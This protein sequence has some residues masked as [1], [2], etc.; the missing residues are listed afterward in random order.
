MTTKAATS[1]RTPKEPVLF[2]GMRS[3][4]TD[5][6]WAPSQ[7]LNS[8]LALPVR[9][10]SRQFFLRSRGSAVNSLRGFRCFL[11]VHKY[12][13]IQIHLLGDDR[14]RRNLAKTVSYLLLAT[15]FWLHGGPRAY[16]E[17]AGV[18]GAG[19][20][21]AR[22]SSAAGASL[23]PGEDFQF[24]SLLSET[25][26]L[27]ERDEAE[28]R[29][30]PEPEKG[31]R[32]IRK[33]FELKERLG[34]ENEKIRVYFDKL[35]DFIKRK[36]LSGEI[37]SRH[38]EFVRHYQTKYQT[39]EQKLGEIESTHKDA[40][41]FWGR[42][43]GK[44]KRVNWDGVLGKALVFLKENSPSA[45]ERRFDPKNLPNRTLRPEKPVLPK[46]TIDEWRQALPEYSG[47]AAAP[48]AGSKIEP[49][50]KLFATA[51]P[52]SADLAETVEVKFT[53]D[54]KDLADSLGRNPVKI[55][56]WVRN[57]IEFVP[58]WGSIQ[59]AQLCLENRAG[60][61]FDT[62][63]LLI[64]LLRYSGIHA[65]YQMGTIE[66]PIEK[67][68]NWA[69][70]FTSAEAA[71][72]LFAS[73]GVPSVVRRFDQ[74]G[75]VAGVK[76]EHIWVKGFV[77]YVPSAGVIN[78]QGDTWIDLDASF[79]QHT[80]PSPVDLSQFIAVR[81]ARAFIDRTLAGAT[82]NTV[83]SEVTQLDLDYATNTLRPNESSIENY[84]LANFPNKSVSDVI[85]VGKIVVK[86][87]PVLPTPLP[88][89]VI[90]L[91]QSFAEL[92]ASLRH[93]V[94]L[95]LSDTAGADILRYTRSL[96][97]L[98]GSRIILGYVPAAE[99]D[100]QALEALVPAV[101][102]ELPT[103]I[104]TRIVN[105]KAELK[106]NNTVAVSGTV[107]RLGSAQKLQMKFAAPTI[108]TSVIENDVL[109]GEIFAIALDL[110]QVA[111]SALK[112]VSDGF[113]RIASEVQAN[114]S[115]PNVSPR[116]VEDLLLSG[117]ALCWF[118]EVDLVGHLAAPLFGVVNLRYPSAGMAFS[119]LIPVSLFG[120]T[121]QVRFGGVRMDVD[122]DIVVTE[123][124]N[125]DRIAAT[126]YSLVS[127][128]IG[129][130]L[131]NSVPEQFLHSGQNTDLFWLSTTAAGAHGQ[132]LGATTVTL[133]NEN[134]STVE[135]RLSIPAS[136]RTNLKDALNSGLMVLVHER[137]IEDRGGNQF[138]GYMAF[139]PRTGSSSQILSGSGGSVMTRCTNPTA[140]LNG[141][142]GAVTGVM[143]QAGISGIHHLI[144]SG[145]HGAGG[146]VGAC[147]TLAHLVTH[148]EEAFHNSNQLISG[149]GAA[150]V[151]AGPLLGLMVMLASLDVLK[152][153]LEVSLGPIGVPVPGLGYLITAG[154]GVVQATAY[155]LVDLFISRFLV[156][157]AAI[158]GIE[159]DP[160]C[161]SIL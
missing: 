46:L 134:F 77:D 106:I 113:R 19:G 24:D 128:I 8:K 33:L 151:H 124:K 108:R 67:F 20:R 149:L 65:R 78:N 82:T 147:L 139:D 117:I 42:V 121:Y 152:G 54:I 148:T 103:V 144:D 86:N 66:V 55:F 56:N 88:N 1:R 73:A 100:R 104:P 112:A 2:G 36:G 47:K 70:G 34:E 21:T 143:L 122:R 14:M 133:T 94:E 4:A 98:A 49:E 18:M 154:L 120:A 126:H 91:G 31:F 110:Q 3:L 23:E 38:E 130:G 155:K 141:F 71:A 44:N 10:D 140:Y 158:A 52:T 138:L 102:G 132:R 62:A 123:S 161:L 75:K 11:R 15:M 27:L 87:F 135:P 150:G 118:R 129:S 114:A 156:I 157:D 58:T 76:L 39:L 6:V 115:N 92:P 12:G 69:G 7:S 101:P 45:P 160:G 41:G 35:G 51:P 17:Y 145:V 137:L 93:T 85:G 72:S 97:E 59:G 105:M 159:I 81:D 83:T 68:K 60:N 142:N 153:I 119:D 50:T 63:S 40:T 131:E 5:L 109:A 37:L 61:A 13:G 30:A 9:R 28:R 96:P 43:T 111:P 89:S 136:D 48:A 53:Q 29:S 80:Y 90:V 16:A 116:E 99:A 146:F 22:D 26:K 125:G 95:T 57:N 64:A 84:F 79:K 25:K 32:E 74:S 107:A 127:G